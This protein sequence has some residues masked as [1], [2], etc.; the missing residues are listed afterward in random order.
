MEKIT[1]G[2]LCVWG[3]GILSNEIF[4]VMIKLIYLNIQVLSQEELCALH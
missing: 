4:V 3:G 2:V 1:T